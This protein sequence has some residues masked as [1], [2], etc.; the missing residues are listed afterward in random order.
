MSG[1]SQNKSRTWDIN[2]QVRYTT[3]IDGAEQIMELT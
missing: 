2:E 3:I 1:V